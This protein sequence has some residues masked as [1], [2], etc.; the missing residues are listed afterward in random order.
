MPLAV[1]KI[2]LMI[3]VL[4]QVYV[5]YE[6]APIY[7][8]NSNI[9][10]CGFSSFYSLFSFTTAYKT[11]SFT[12]M[13]NFIIF[14]CICSMV[15]YVDKINLFLVLSLSPTLLNEIFMFYNT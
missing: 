8:Q 11:I 2:V 13:Y 14:F 3:R 4:Q 10:N 6:N 12:I 5:I 7:L 9:I 15:K 1:E